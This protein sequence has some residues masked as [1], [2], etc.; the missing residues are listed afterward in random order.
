MK[1]VFLC[2]DNVN[3]TNADV[4]QR[5]N[6]LDRYYHYQVPTW[7]FDKTK[8]LG[9]KLNELADKGVD[10]VVVSALGN[11][12]RMGSIDDHVVNTCIESDAP[13]AGHLIARNGY[14]YL[15]PQF[16]CLNLKQWDTVGRPG[17]D[18]EWTKQKFTSVAVARSEQN[19]H[20]DYTPHWI[21]PTDGTTE[22]SLGYMPFGAKVL[23]AFL[24]NGNTCINIDDQIRNRKEYLYPNSYQE[25]LAKLFADIT[26]KPESIPL[27]RFIKQINRLFEDEQRTVFVLN[28]EA[29]WPHGPSTAGIIDQY[30]GVCGGLKAVGVLSRSGFNETTQVNLID[31]SAPALAYQ[32]YLVENWDGNWDNYKSQLDEFSRTNPGLTY[33]WRSWNSWDSE[34]DAFLESVGLSKETFIDVWNKYRKLKFTYTHIN[35]LDSN[36]LSSYITNLDGADVKNFYIWV[37]NAFHMEHTVAKHGTQWLL[38]KSAFLDQCLKEL[39]ATVWLEKDN[40]LKRLK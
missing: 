11:F 23:R 18:E 27:Q 34:I 17:F 25:E 3:V 5:L 6:D 26:Y 13:I 35:L 37:S 29:G 24:E 2:Y 40:V 32:Q 10:F 22:Y 19:F 28:S 21:K 20:D 1:K 33:A 8:D 39:N 12:L 16:F 36:A 30:I 9:P 31:I 38:D 14:Y 15:D 4:Y 7:E